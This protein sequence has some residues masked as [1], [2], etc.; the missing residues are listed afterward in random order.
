VEAYTTD[1]N[2]IVP[3]TTAASERFLPTRYASVLVARCWKF[4][5]V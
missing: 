5:P 3:V 1:V 2:D 4:K